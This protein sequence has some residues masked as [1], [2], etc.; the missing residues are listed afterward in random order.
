MGAVRLGGPQPYV[1][2][3][4][5]RFKAIVKRGLIGYP[6]CSFFV[7]A[8]SLRSLAQCTRTELPQIISTLN[9]HQYVKGTSR[10]DIRVVAGLAG[11]KRAVCRVAD[12]RGQP[13]TENYGS[14][15]QTST[16]GP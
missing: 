9:C 10:G 2:R 1:W 15:W 3:A 11:C 16:S 5:G 7:S 12:T 8:D 13:R 14:I 6:S 4:S